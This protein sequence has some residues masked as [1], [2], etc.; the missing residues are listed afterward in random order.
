[1]PIVPSR[2]IEQFL[3]HLSCNRNV[4]ASTQRQALNAI[5]FLY[6]QVLNIPIDEEL[7]HSRSKRHPSLPV[8]LSQKEVK[9]VLDQMQG[10]HLLMDSCEAQPER[11]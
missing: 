8:V 1:M 5:I 4:A 10:I 6:K 3:S 2:L 11:S 9:L 7:E